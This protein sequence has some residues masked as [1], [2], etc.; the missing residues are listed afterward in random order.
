MSD[1]GYLLSKGMRFSFGRGIYTTPELSVALRYADAFTYNGQKHKF[2]LQ[3]RVNPETI[4]R[5]SKVRTGLGE[6]WISQ[7]DF[8]VRPY[9]ICFMKY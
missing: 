5:I 1:E 7:N 6:Y 9:G 3:N 8:D 4:E 2:I